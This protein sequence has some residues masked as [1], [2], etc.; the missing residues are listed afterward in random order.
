MSTQTKAVR[1]AATNP[2][3]VSMAEAGRRLGVSVDTIRRRIQ[4]G[5]LPA[6]RFGPTVVRIPVDAIEDALRAVPTKACAD[7]LD[8]LEAEI[9]RAVAAAPPLSD[10]RR[11]RIVAL[12]GGA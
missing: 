1:A 12:L 9:Q 3:H 11:A 7:P 8:R 4:D 10:E 2:T 5:T 6:Q